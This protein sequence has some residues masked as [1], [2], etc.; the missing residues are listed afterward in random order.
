[1][2]TLFTLAESS[3]G[4]VEAL[5]QRVATL[6]TFKTQKEGLIDSAIQG[7]KLGTVSETTA[8]NGVT[9]QSG[10]KM[11]EVAGGDITLDLSELV[12]DC[13]EF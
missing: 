2:L 11:K 9:I 7:G 8:G 3:T 10:A 4:D 12:I 6:E 5:E 13:G 1:M